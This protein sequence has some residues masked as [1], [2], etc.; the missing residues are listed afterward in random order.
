MSV[1]LRTD[2]GAARPLS[3]F[4]Q[5]VL[6]LDPDTERR[7]DVPGALSAVLEAAP[8]F[9]R[10][11]AG[12]DRFQVD[13]Y[14]R[15]A[16]DEIAVAA[17][18]REHLVDRHLRTRAELEEARQLLSHSAGG[19]EFLRVSDRIGSVLAVAAD[20]AESMRAE[21]EAERA[22]VAAQAAQTIAHGHQMLADAETEAQRMVAEAA[23]VVE[24]MATEAARIVD[25]AEQT[26]REARAEAEARLEKVRLVEQRAIEQA[27]GIREQALVEATAARL[28]AR[29]EI[30]RMLGTAREERRRADAEALATRVRLDRDAEARSDALRVEIAALER[31]RSAL[32]AEVELLATMVPAPTSRRLE[33]HLRRLL[34][35][36]SLRPRSLRAP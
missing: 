9:R 19:G 27:A 21:A 26:G 17:R 34:E 13:S 3:A 24:E 4:E 33:V 20:E 11:V 28:A 36:R 12:Y 25:E 31:R 8:M 29:E 2:D 6:G 30:V 23:T 14:V 32:R 1:E 7:P 5:V 22:A 10:T 35:R 18:E 15:W 16:E